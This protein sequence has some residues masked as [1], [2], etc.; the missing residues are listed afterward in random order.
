MGLLWYTR[1]MIGDATIRVVY[2]TETPEAN[3]GVF[4]RI[5]SRPIEP[6]MPVMRGYEVQIN[7]AEDDFH[8]TGVLYS[9][10]EAQARPG[11]VGEWNTMEI[12][13]DGFRTIV[14]VNGEV[15]TDY[16]EGDPVPEKAIWW[17]PDRGRRPLYGYIG[18]QNHGPEDTVYVREIS[19]RPL[20]D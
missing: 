11:K 5:P 8:A 12:T 16:T 9:L 1:D 7:E 2:R 15:V 3:G 6:W 19:I 17:E 18:I 4:I 13:L 14:E 10:T 20:D